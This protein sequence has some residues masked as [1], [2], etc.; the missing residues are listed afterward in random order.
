MCSWIGGFW[1]GWSTSLKSHLAARILHGLGSA[2]VEGLLPLIMQDI[3]FIHQRNR[4]IAA[5]LACQGPLL[6]VFGHRRTVYRHQLLVA[7]DLLDHLGSWRARLV[8][9]HRLCARD[10]QDA[11]QA[12]AEYV[13]PPPPPPPSPPLPPR[14]FSVHIYYT[15]AA[16]YSLISPGP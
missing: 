16:D 13:V 9:Y 3:V 10:A 14:P 2:T 6:T 8:L 15:C 11:V 12:G 1:A 4:A 7:V 5:I